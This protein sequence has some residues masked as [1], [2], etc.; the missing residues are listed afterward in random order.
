[1]LMKKRSLPLK[2]ALAPLMLACSLVAS[3]CS[4]ASM[5][6]EAA[7]EFTITSE[8]LR[9]TTSILPISLLVNEFFSTE[10][11][12]GKTPFVSVD[13]LLTGPASPHH[14]AL[15]AS[16]AKQLSRSDLLV[17]VGPEFELFLQ[18]AAQKLPA[19]ELK[20]DDGVRYADSSGHNHYDMHLWLDIEI[21]RHFGRNL[22]QWLARHVPK[23]RERWAA[24]AV[25]YDTE[26]VSLDE[27]LKAS[28]QASKVAPFVAYHD[29]FGS[30]VGHYQLP[31]QGS[32]TQVPDEQIS[33]RR[34]AGFAKREALGAAC[35]VAEASEAAHAARYAKILNLPLV[36]VDLLANQ[37]DY[38][39]YRDYMHA[40]AAAFQSCSGNAEASTQD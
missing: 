9:I 8:Q 1:M 19:I 18:K 12:D 36:E 24:L 38:T 6:T 16:H 37:Q 29:A 25:R 32:L 14:F 3:W 4:A 5:P 22:H 17:W 21:A 2:R 26:M 27:S 11:V 40:I 34:L 31:Q 15:R 39:G 7:P 13:A 33:A 35:M 23:Q 28:F 20:E 30:M 10:T